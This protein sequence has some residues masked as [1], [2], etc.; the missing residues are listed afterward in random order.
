MSPECWTRA[1]S[2]G[3]RGHHAS[4]CIT[5]GWNS[6]ALALSSLRHS[7]AS[8]TTSM[9]RFPI[10]QSQLLAVVLL[11]VAAVL[12][13]AVRA[14]RHGVDA[15]PYPN[16]MAA[17]GDSWTTSYCTDADCTVKPRDSWSTGWNPAIDSHY[18]RILAKNRKIHARNYNIADEAGIVAAGIGDLSLLA[19]DAIAKKVDYVTIALGE[20]DA[21]SSSPAYFRAQFKAGMDKL[22]KGLPNANIFV[23]SI[24]DL[25]RQW[26]AM[27]ADRKIRSYVNLDCGLDPRPRRNNSTRSESRSSP[28]TRNSHPS[29]PITR[30]AATTAEPSSGS[31]GKSGTSH[32]SITATY[33]WPDNER[34]LPPP[35][36][37]PSPSASDSA[38]VASVA[39]WCWSASR[40]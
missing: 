27:H 12:V 34:S 3:S 30:A 1:K 19:G 29:A 11:A 37:R 24:D 17:I 40:E 9:R 21:C 5:L 38:S 16:S 13:P 39:W 18:L 31:P 10:R 8:V 22:T 14:A 35:G 6:T 36:K 26:Q 28:S 23:A 20:N 33:R 32:P 25:T 4:V 7:A 2:D 15:V